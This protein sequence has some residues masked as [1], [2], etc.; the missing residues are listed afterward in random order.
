M[1]FFYLVVILSTISGADLIA[2]GCEPIDI[3][4]IGTDTTR[5]YT[6]V[7]QFP[8]FPGWEANSEFL[9]KD[10]RY[11]GN[12]RDNEKERAIVVAFTVE[13]DGSLTDIKILKSALPSYDVDAIRAVSSMPKWKPATNNGVV[14]RCRYK[15]YI[16]YPP[17]QENPSSK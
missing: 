3:N 16:V 4:T 11:S 14:V 17:F 6:Y 5:V 15:V 2:Q 10:I 13:K 8:Q 1:K 12:P 9:K 7:G